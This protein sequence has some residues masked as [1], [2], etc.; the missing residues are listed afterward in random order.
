MSG[1]QSAL[2]NL[3]V[4]VTFLA[5]FYFLLIRPNQKREKA[6]KAMRAS[7]K[8]GDRVMTIGG[9]G[10]EILSL[11][12][13]A[14]VLQVEPDKTRITVEKWGIGRIV[15]GITETDLSAQDEA[16]IEETIVEA[17]EQESGV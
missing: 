10:G 17:A 2:V 13:D 14:V 1:Q 6:I 4:P 11:S 8:I 5:M 3:L 15:E 16:L 12:E 9:I 7:L